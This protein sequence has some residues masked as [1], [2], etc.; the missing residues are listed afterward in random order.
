MSTSTA[1]R[2]TTGDLCVTSAVYRFDGYLD[3]S[4]TPRPHTEEEQIPLSRGER[5]PPI[6]SA[7]KSCFWVLHR[8]A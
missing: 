1:T 7:G 2:F 8:R 3:G 5:F 6:R 4:R